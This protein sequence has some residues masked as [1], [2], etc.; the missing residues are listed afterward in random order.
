MISTVNLCI[1]CTIHSFLA[2]LT[3][4]RRLGSVKSRKVSTQSLQSN[5]S[6][7]QEGE[8]PEEADSG[9]MMSDEAQESPDIPDQDDQDYS[10]FMPWIKVNITYPCY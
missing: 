9:G 8:P 1:L 10:K 3:G 4:M 5:I 2:Y 7:D 6:I